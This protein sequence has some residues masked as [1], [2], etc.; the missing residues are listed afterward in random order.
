[1]QTR[2]KPVAEKIFK[3]LKND[4]YKGKYLSGTYLPSENSLCEMFTASRGTIR[5]VLGRLEQVGFIRIYPGKGSCVAVT[6]GNAV[7]KRFLTGVNIDRSHIATEFMH[8]LAGVCKGS[9][10]LNAEAILA[11]DAI[12]H[13]R[14]I[15]ERYVSG[16]IDGVLYIECDDYNKKIAPLEKAGIPCV[17]ANLENNM[18]CVSAKVDFRHTG[19]IAARHLLDHGH[20]N[21]ALLIGEN[22]FYKEM[23]AGFRGTLAEENI[24]LKDND[25]YIANTE[26]EA[27][28]GSKKILNNRNR[29]SAVFAGRDYK[30][31]IFY[32]ACREERVNIPEEI[33]IVSYDD[34]T[35]D[36]SSASGLTSISEPAEE[37]GKVAV[38]LLCKWIEAN[39]RPASVVLQ[40]SLKKNESVKL[41]CQK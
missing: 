17:V 18:D 12:R 1:M 15:I 29:Y 39:K 16:S 10:E 32:Q 20:R 2:R 22:F 3:S 30:A 5:S 21:C 25:I 33:S 28:L 14:E 8:I 35:W 37:M 34:I 23:A 19:R 40:G 11:F 26:E 6:D 38:E 36:E 9:A 41:Y 31:S 24:F 27:L 7:K 4:I 13:P